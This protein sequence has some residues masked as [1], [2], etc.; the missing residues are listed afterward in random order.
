MHVPVLLQEVLAQL[1]PEDGATYVDAT[2]GGGGYTQALLNAA[3][4]RVVALDRDPEA[5]R[6]AEALAR[7]YPDRFR[8]VLTPF[9]QVGPALKDN[10]EPSRLRGIVFDFGVS[11]FQIDTP[12]RGFSF[13]KDGP[14]DMRMSKAG[15]TAADVVNTFSQQDLTEL[16]HTYGEEPRA[17]QISRAITTRRKQSPFRTTLELADLVRSIVPRVGVLDP[18]TKTFQAIRIFVNDELREIQDALQAV[19]ALVEEKGTPEV[20]VVTVAF[21][22]LEDRVVKNWIRGLEAPDRT[23]RAVAATRHVIT[24]SEEEL[25]TN[26]RSRSGRLRAVTLQRTTKPRKAEPPRSH[27]HSNDRLS[28][29]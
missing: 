3:A 28:Y 20:R 19:E 2:F 17:R 16:L 27:S 23:V 21:H 9:S 7:E 12:E 29:K 5:K 4:C 25:K 6:R 22:A 13:Q 1:S 24:P 26:V 14:L 11:S 18:A 15:L 10:A 8:F